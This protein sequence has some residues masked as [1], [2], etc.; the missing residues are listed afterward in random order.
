MSTTQTL[1]V[2]AYSPQIA[3]L[4]HAEE[5]GGLSPAWIVL[6]LG[7]ADL[8][9]EWTHSSDTAWS[10]AEHHGHTVRWGVDPAMTGYHLDR[11]LAQVVPLA[12]RMYAGYT[13]V[14]DG[15]NHVADLTVDAEAAE[16]EIRQMLEASTYE[17]S[18]RIVYTHP[19]Q[20]SDGTEVTA[21]STD[22]ELEAAAQA[23]MAVSD[24]A[25]LYLYT[26]QDARKHYEYCRTR[27]REE[28]WRICA[29]CDAEWCED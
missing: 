28:H 29:G 27:D 23:L 17:G 1:T 6:S 26:V 9:A 2:E 22:A 19:S 10:A 8:F 12:E 20:V 21:H 7:S 5:D 15:S 16:E 4:A 3:P 24:D 25:E 13:S 11:L 14:W 18:D